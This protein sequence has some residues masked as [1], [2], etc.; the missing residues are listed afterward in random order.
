MIKLNNKKKFTFLNIKNHIHLVNL[1][2]K[3]KIGI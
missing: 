1:E 3:I 2:L